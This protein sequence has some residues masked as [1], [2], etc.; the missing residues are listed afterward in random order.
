MHA[1]ECLW[2][3]GRV[4]ACPRV[5][6]HLRACLCMR[7]R[8][9]ACVSMFVHAQAFIHARACLFAHE[10]VYAR[11]SVVMCARA[12]FCAHEGVFACAYSYVCILMHKKLHLTHILSQ[13]LYQFAG[14]VQR[15]PIDEMTKTMQPLQWKRRQNLKKKVT[16]I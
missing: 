5:F 10:R 15:Q 11:A 2:L 16:K 4:H 13:S 8:V 3:C 9:C 1:Q 12:C 6:L 14:L 7:E